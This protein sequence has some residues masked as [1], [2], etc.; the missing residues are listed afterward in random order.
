MR[1]LTFPETG[2]VESELIRA[3]LAG[4]HPLLA[5]LRNQYEI[6]KLVDRE[7]T[8][9]GFYLTFAVDAPAHRLELPDV[10]IDDVQ[11]E[12]EGLERGG[13]AIAHV[14]N[15]YL[16]IVEAYL[17]AEAWPRTPRL[18]RVY[19]DTGDQRDLALLSRVWQKS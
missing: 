4:D 19:Y 2:G 14:T 11:F 7:L 13:G 17:S 5:A 1:I 6:A 18:R 16:H 12:L 8:G 15:G 9:S 10:A 3:L